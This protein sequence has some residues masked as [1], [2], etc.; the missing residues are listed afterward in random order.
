MSTALP[1]PSKSTLILLIATIAAGLWIPRQIK[2]VRDRRWIREAQSQLTVS[3]DRVTAATEALESAQ[4]ALRA[5]NDEHD[6][7]LAAV[8]KAGR[9]AAAK[10]PDAR[11]ATP[12]ASLPEWNAESPYVWLRK[13]MVSRLPMSPFTEDGQL[14]PEVGYVLVVDPAVQRD[15]NNQL[16]QLLSD[17]RALEVAKAEQ[18]DEPLPGIYG[19]KNQIVTIR[20]QPLVEEGARVKQQFEAALIGSLGAQRAELL[21]K[22]GDTWIGSEFAQ[23]GAEPK[24]I[25]VVRHSADS[26]NVSIKTGNNWISTGGPAKAVKDQIPPHLRPLFGE[27]FD[28]GDT[29]SP[30]KGNP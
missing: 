5:A 7:V 22:A 11:W 10:D 28:E 4:R 26:Y 2:M 8:A 27:W 25:S 14:R 29:A 16:K 20:V 23:F 6:R 9:L 21:L 17:Y 13:E 19:E 1:R 24:I 12:P 18:I 15:L 3:H 30:A